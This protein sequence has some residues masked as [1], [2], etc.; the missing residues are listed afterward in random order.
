MRGLVDDRLAQFVD[1]TL[2]ALTLPVEFIRVDGDAVEFKL[3]QD[4]D[5]GQL[6][7]LIEVGQPKRIDLG[8]QTFLELQ[9]DVGI[10][11]RVR[12]GGVEI[13]FAETICFLPLPMISVIET[14]RRPSSFSES[15]FIE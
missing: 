13:G 12:P 10:L 1:P 6:G 2:Q 3:G 15:A 11:R 8:T 4:L 14:Q 9:G 7:L 5:Q